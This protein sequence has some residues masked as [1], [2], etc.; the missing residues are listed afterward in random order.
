VNRHAGKVLAVWQ[1]STSDGARVV[2]W[3]DTGAPDQQWQLVPVS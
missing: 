2:Q 3:S 1:G